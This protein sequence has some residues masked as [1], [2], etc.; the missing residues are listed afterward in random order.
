MRLF[1]EWTFEGRPKLRVGSDG[2]NRYIAT[3]CKY[4]EEAF[5]FETGGTAIYS[6]RIHKLCSGLFLSLISHAPRLTERK[7]AKNETMATLELKKNSATK[8]N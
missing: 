3:V 4:G 2:G 7:Y 5:C 6:P 1:G 8:D